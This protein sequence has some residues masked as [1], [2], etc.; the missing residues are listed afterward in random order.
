MRKRT[1]R[2]AIPIL[3]FL[4]C[5]TILFAVTPLLNNEII[6]NQV[7][8]QAKSNLIIDCSF[9]EAGKSD[10]SLGHAFELANN[11]MK[12]LIWLAIV[13]AGIVI[14]WK[15]MKLATNV[16]W[17]G[18]Y[19]AA[20]ENFQK[21]LKA[22]FIGIFL[23]LSAYLIVRAAFNIVGYERDPFEYKSEQ[24][25]TGGGSPTLPS[26][27]PEP[28]DGAL[29]G[30]DGCQKKLT[31]SGID[32]KKGNKTGVNAGCKNPGGGTDCWVS[33]TLYNKL[34]NLDGD[35]SD[36]T[37]WW[38]TEA[39]PPTIRHAG[40]DNSCHAT[41]N[42]TCVD[43]NFYNGGDA[44]RKNH[45]FQEIYAFIKK[46]EK[47]YLRAVYEVKTSGDLTTF[48]QGVKPFVEQGNPTLNEEEIDQIV[49]RYVIQANITGKHFSVY[50]N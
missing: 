23:I 28:D 17:P 9:G 27:Q 18:G 11:I 4:L 29:S 8:A 13:G 34:T 30:C 46:A 7:L 24:V 50:S 15:G 5:G 41:K 42:C 44:S 25:Q 43:V 35:T 3:L 31:S 21:A 37:D 47:H 16:F 6:D 2:R 14:T 45:T 36:P 49:N 48:R 1:I 32:Y 33:T 40:G 22:I 38:I 10:C 19:N 39:C 20:R 12:L 26:T